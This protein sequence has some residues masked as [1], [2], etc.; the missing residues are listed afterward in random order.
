MARK[1]AW[2]VHL[3]TLSSESQLNSH[4]AQ[5]SFI[6]C[7]S[8]QY[9][10]FLLCQRCQ[11]PII[12]SQKDSSKF[13]Y[14][15]QNSASFVFIPNKSLFIKNLFFY[16]DFRFFHARLVRF[17][18]LSMLGVGFLVFFLPFLPSITKFCQDPK[19]H[20]FFNFY[21][22]FHFSMLG[23]GIFAFF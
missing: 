12:L 11:E 2:Q 4:S 5:A 22:F 21:L 10:H 16:S 20:L 8:L 17:F 6:Q 9:F 19:F 1:L 14:R 15:T 7:N 13:M 18:A 23:L 3:F